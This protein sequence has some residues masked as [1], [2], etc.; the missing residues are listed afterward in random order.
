MDLMLRAQSLLVRLI[1][2]RHPTVFG[3]RASGVGE[4]GALST[5]VG[6]THSAVHGGCVALILIT[7]DYTLVKKKNCE[8]QLLRYED[9]ILG[10]RA[11]W[12]LPY[13]SHAFQSILCHS[14]LV[15]GAI[16]ESLQEL[17]KSKVLL[18]TPNSRIP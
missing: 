1:S 4:L 3:Q 17:K 9:H 12:Q 7:P 16:L 5:Q 14:R 11:G 6:G 13:F 10:N 18:Q 2:Q 15:G 8:H